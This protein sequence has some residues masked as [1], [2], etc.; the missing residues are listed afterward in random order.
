MGS[1]NRQRSY[2]LTLRVNAEEKAIIER[3]A[4]QCS[5][6]VAAYLRNLG[7]GYLPKS[8][9][10]NQ[11]LLELAR[12]KGDM[13][14]VGGLLKMWLSSKEKVNLGRQLNIPELIDELKQLTE[15][16]KQFFRHL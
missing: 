3:L 2:K 12:L 15:Q 7:L 5:L 9:L 1:E 13:G 14:R 8:T 11:L 10:D 16:A 4:S 6:S